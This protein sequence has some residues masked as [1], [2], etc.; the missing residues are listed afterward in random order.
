MSVTLYALFPE[1]YVPQHSVL[2]THF[3]KADEAKAIVRSDGRKSAVVTYM[4]RIVRVM[5]HG[6]PMTRAEI[7]R[8]AGVSKNCVRDN[9]L[10]LMKQGKV[11]MSGGRLPLYWWVI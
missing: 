11:H 2:E 10:E 3:H 9:V 8:K 6:D 5:K 4:D 7:Q 1:Q